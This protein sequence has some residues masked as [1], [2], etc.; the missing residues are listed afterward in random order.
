[1]V[2]M[3]ISKRGLLWFLEMPIQLFNASAKNFSSSPP[4]MEKKRKKI[5]EKT[6]GA[7]KK[8]PEYVVEEFSN[9]STYWRKNELT[10][11]PR[12]QCIHENTA[13]L[14]AHNHIQMS[15]ATG[16]L[17][18]PS[19]YCPSQVL[20]LTHWLPEINYKNICAQHFIFSFYQRHTCTFKYLCSYGKSIM[21]QVMSYQHWHS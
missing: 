5:D 15:P 17:G 8:Y 13:P 9:K 12:H 18:I 21:S 20:C 7:L 2:T 11:N 14:A 1:M 3:S 6:Y 16:A 19:A 4:S 10:T